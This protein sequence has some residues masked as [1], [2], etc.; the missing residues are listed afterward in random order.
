[1]QLPRGS[2]VLPADVVSA[3]GE[4]N[5]AAGAADIAK[6]IHTLPKLARGGRVDP[7]NV[8]VSDGEFAVHPNHVAAIGGGSLERGHAL[9]DR[10]V[11]GARAKAARAAATMPGPQ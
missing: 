3:H 10:F 1:M 9:L 2:Y 4:G 5:T 6:H 7:V 11:Q 8:R